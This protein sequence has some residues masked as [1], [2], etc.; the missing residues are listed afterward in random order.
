MTGKIFLRVRN[1]GLGISRAAACVAHAWYVRGCLVT[2]AAC[3]RTIADYTMAQ[4]YS[5]SDMDGADG[6]LYVIGVCAT[7]GWESEEGE[8]EQIEYWK[9]TDWD[10]C[11]WCELPHRH[12]A[13][14]L[15]LT[16]AVCYCGG[17]VEFKCGK[18]KDDYSDS[19]SD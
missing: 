4:I 7:D 3:L 19:D 17:R 16:H 11:E 2:S 15:L 5:D 6:E 13:S 18:L 12:V 9:D 1:D 8:N 14:S 10:G